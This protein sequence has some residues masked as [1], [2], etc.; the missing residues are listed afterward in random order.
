MRKLI[1]QRWFRLCA[2]VTLVLLF[3]GSLARPA[4]AVEFDDDG[5]VAKD[6]IINDDLF[7]SSGASM[8]DGTVNGDLFISANTAVVN[9]TV[10][11]NLLYYGSELKLNGV[12]NGS[13]VSYCATAKINGQISGSLYIGSLKVTLEPQARIGRNL[14]SFVMNLFTQPGSLVQRDFL[15]STLVSKLEGEIGRNVNMNVDALDLN[16]KVGGNVNLNIEAPQAGEPFTLNVNNVGPLMIAP[17][18]LGGLHV[19]PEAQ[20]AGQLA[21]SSSVEQSEA[22]KATPKDGVK[23]TKVQDPTAQK[24]LGQ[25]ISAA[26]LKALHELVALLVLGAL[27]AWLAPQW[28]VRAAEQARRPLPAFGWGFLTLVVGYALS[29]GAAILLLI[30]IVLMIA[31]SLTDLVFVSLTLGSASLNFVVTSLTA[32]VLFGSKLVVAY[33][34]GDWLFKRFW[35]DYKGPRFVP[36]AVGLVIYKLIELIPGIGFIFGLLVTLVGLG[37]IWLA[38]RQARA[39]AVAPT[40]PS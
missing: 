10:N 21:Y 14:Y 25:K 7:I 35:P 4:Q 18:R 34:G 16:G 1:Q 9:G 22:I 32:L 17:N 33:L 6:E 38:H 3:A 12:V 30:L 31:V 27:V 23:F 15:G 19:S 8:I 24:T 39:A 26:L 36:L 28:L 5:N 29:I 11:G 20:I 40:N 37:A 13:V 2:A